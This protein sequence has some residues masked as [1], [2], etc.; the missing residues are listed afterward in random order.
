MKWILASERLPEKEGYY[1]CR[2]TD[3]G[4]KFVSKWNEKWSFHAAAESNINKLE[5]L[6][7]SL[8]DEILGDCIK[9][10]LADIEK[11]EPEFNH[12]IKQWDSY[13]NI[14]NNL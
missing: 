10:L 11:H 7:E 5:W 6:D 8:P 13:T 4:D 12:I 14:Q 1:F 2:W 9:Q 3:S